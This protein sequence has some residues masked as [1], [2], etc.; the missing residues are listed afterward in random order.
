MLNNLEVQIISIVMIILQIFV[1]TS[2]RILYERKDAEKIE[3]KVVIVLYFSFS[4]SSR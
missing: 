2:I 3:A 4:Q 1:D